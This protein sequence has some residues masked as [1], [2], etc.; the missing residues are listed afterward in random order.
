MN[1]LRAITILLSLV[2]TLLF[3][4]P[5]SA[6]TL[7]LSP[8]SGSIG[9]GCSFSVDIRIDT[10]GVESDSADVVLLYNPQQVSASSIINGTIFT[11][12][13]GNSI[14]N[15]EGKVRIYALAAS[16]ASFT[17][18]GSM[19]T[20][21]FIASSSAQLTQTP[22]TLDFDPLTPTKTTD[23][24][25]I[26]KGSTTD[27]LSSVANGSYTVSN[28]SC[29]AG[30]SSTTSQSQGQTASES[31][32]VTSLPDTGTTENTLIFIGAGLVLLIVGIAGMS[33]NNRNASLRLRH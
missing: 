16:N 17:G 33:Y 27:I 25:V 9:R 7:S 11:D 23:S 26:Q 30:L 8:T 18:S 29:L 21:N 6:A 1:N 31:A 20:V 4:T 22:I 24:N 3:S 12:Y 13:P 28:A 5:A 32:T 2:A 14:D 19:A 10:S 15:T